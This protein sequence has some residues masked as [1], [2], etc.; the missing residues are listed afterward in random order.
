MKFLL[1]SFLLLFS[2]A[3]T[4]QQTDADLQAIKEL[5]QQQESLWNAG[6]ID[7]FMAV[8]YWQSPELKFI[9]KGGIS[10]GYEATRKGYHQRYPDR[11][12][13]G[14]LNF[15]LLS[16]EKLGPKSAMVVGKWQL[17]RKTDAP[18]GH[19]TLIWKK[20]KG[21]WVIVADHTS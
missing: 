16:V 8:G 19:F 6:D 18:S 3:A 20:I 21:K 10:Y 4:A 15:E 7:G 1:V 9:G 5:L 17:Q 2:L 11:S 13:M 14:Q 12:A